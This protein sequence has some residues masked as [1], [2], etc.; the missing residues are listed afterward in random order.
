[1]PL[2]SECFAGCKKKRRLS[3]KMHLTPLLTTA[4]TDSATSLHYLK[5]FLSFLLGLP[6]PSVLAF[7]IFF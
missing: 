1:M 4:A 7:R 3:T 2:L 5:R 6:L